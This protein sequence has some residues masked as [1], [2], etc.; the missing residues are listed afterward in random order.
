MCLELKDGFLNSIK[1]GKFIFNKDIKLNFSKKE[2][3]EFDKN[4]PNKE[5][6]IL[7][8]QFRTDYEK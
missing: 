4:F 1:R 5:K 7:P 8:G 3:E 6:K 2:L